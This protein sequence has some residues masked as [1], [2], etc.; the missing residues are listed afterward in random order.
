M[1]IEKDNIV[2]RSANID[3]AIQLNKWWNDGK[4]MA[5]A[6]F[7]KGL[8]QSLED[9]I[10]QIRKYE[11]KLSQV[12]IIEIDGKN[13]GELNYRIKDDGSVYP[14][15]K[16]CDLDY[17]NQGYGTEIIKILFKFLFSDENINSKFSVDRITWDTMLENKRAQYIY[18]KKI[19]ARKIGIKENAWKDQLGNLRSSV[20]YEITRED[21][22]NAR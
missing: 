4:I 11:G 20:E 7:P 12:C 6:G 17:Q 21:F 2:I 19:H 22:F 15:W 10:I 14:G 18:E 5:H 9:T 3:D 16:I 1:R 13:I 8:G